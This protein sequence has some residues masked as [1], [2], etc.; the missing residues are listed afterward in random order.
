MLKNDHMK[1]KIFFVLKAIFPEAP[2]NQHSFTCFYVISLKE[3]HIM[4]ETVHFNE[5]EVMLREKHFN[6]LY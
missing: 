3:N 5:E 2:N 1:S 6:S 4:I